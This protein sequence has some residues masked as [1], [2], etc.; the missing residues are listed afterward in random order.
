MGML[1]VFQR[2][3]FS[4]LVQSVCIRGLSGQ[5]M[6]F[7]AFLASLWGAVMEFWTAEYGW[8]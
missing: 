3:M 5:G 6:Y 4:L 1:A 7:P 8:K 2:F